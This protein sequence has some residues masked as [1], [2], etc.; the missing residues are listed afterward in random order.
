MYLM[1]AWKNMTLNVLR[2]VGAQSAEQS[3]GI[4][5]ILLVSILKVKS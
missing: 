4:Y 3:V 1:I 5:I 2:I